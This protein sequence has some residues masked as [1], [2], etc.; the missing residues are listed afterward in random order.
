MKIS[1]QKALIFFLALQVSQQTQAM[2]LEESIH[3]A[4]ENSHELKELKLNLESA[5]WGQTKAFA[6]YLPKLEIRG[7][8]LFS[9]R[10]EELEVPFGN[11]TFVMPAIQPYSFFGA[12]ASINIFNGFG[13]ASDVTAAHFRTEAN[14]YRLLRAEDQKR[15]QIR[16]LFYQALGSQILVNVAD[17]N[18]K[19]LQNHLNDVSSRIRSG[20]STKYDSLRVEVQLEDA[21]TEKVAAESNVTIARAKLFDAISI[22]DDGKPLEGQLPEDFS[23]IKAHLLNVDIANRTDRQALVAEYKLSEN[24]VQA[25]KSH[26]YPKVSLFGDYEFYNNINHSV[27]EADNRFKSAYALGVLV[28]W[29]LFDGG[30]HYASQQQAI[31]ASAAASE[32]LARFDQNIPVN[33]EEV[34]RRFSYD[35][36]NYNAKLSNI[37]K[38][39]EAVRL[40]KGGVKAGTR[41]NTEV[42]DAVVDLIRARAS[43]VKSQIDAIDA[44]GQL[45]LALGRT[46]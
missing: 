29:D 11:Q 31:L 22:S 28:S 34:K 24:L 15:V 3:K 12:T 26:W 40:A 46:L 4:F 37:R 18:I 30:A 7:R 2:T 1:F 21:M 44:L 23:R 33:F 14:Q 5:K 35:V 13:T 6:G 20:V 16:T 9:E 8:H 17:Q 38:A 36:L 43:A 25:S 27:S 41:T 19:T 39:E 10:F 45:E 32:R 42:L